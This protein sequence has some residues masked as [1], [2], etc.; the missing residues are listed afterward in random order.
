MTFAG[1]NLQTFDFLRDAGLSPTGA[2]IYFNEHGTLPGPLPAAWP[3]ITDPDPGDPSDPGTPITAHACVSI[4]PDLELLL[5]LIPGKPNL[6]ADLKNF[7]VGKH[8]APGGHTSLL[9]LWHEASTQGPAKRYHDYFSYLDK[10][11]PT[12]KA[13]GLLREAQAYVQGKAQAWKANVKVGAIEVVGTAGT[14]GLAKWMAG[15]LDFYA[16]DIYDTR[17]CDAH[18]YPMLGSF[19][20]TCDGLMSPGRKATIAVTETNSRCS[21]RRPWWF[22]TVW[23]WLQSHGFTSNTSCFL[24]FWRLKATESGGWRPNDTATIEALKKIFERS[25]P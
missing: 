23:S 4:R 18:P 11:Y 24:T 14:S 10:K 2:R 6:D 1:S 21:G 13:A 15:D 16:C 9:A 12:M 8:G 22:H 17:G 25:S 5:G 20:D 3:T 19:K 7:L